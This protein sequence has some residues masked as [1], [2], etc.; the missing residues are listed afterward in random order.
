MLTLTRSFD[1][2]TG[3]RPDALRLVVY[4]LS[5][6]NGE[7][8]R[9]LKRHR[10]PGV[11]IPKDRHGLA[12]NRHLND[13]SR[14]SVVEVLEG[15]GK[16]SSPSPNSAPT[17]NAQHPAQWHLDRKSTRLNSSHI[18]RSRMPSSA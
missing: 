18:T 13:T 10:C 17:W 2:A 4:D 6:L 15:K 3:D 16:P 9:G 5:V 12:L 14:H 11:S 1:S 7:R 8:R